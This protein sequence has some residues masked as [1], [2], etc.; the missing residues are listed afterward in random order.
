MRAVGRAPDEIVW[1]LRCRVVVPRYCGSSAI[2]MSE[3]VPHPRESTAATR[4]SSRY[5]SNTMFRHSIA[6]ATLLLLAGSAYAQDTCG[7]V[8]SS[9]TVT[10]SDALA[11]LRKSV[12][13]PVD[14]Q[15]ASGAT[16]LET[17]QSF[18][19]DEA[20]ETISCTGTGQDAE[21]KKGVA[22]NFTDN[23]DGTITDENTGL[24]WEKLSDDD[25]IHDYDDALYT[26]ED[27]FTQKIATL[28]STNFAGHNDWRLPNLNELETIRNL[29]QASPAVHSEFD[30]ACAPGCTVLTCSCT[31]SDAHWT[32]T[33]YVLDETSAWT[34]YFDDGDTY[35]TA[36]TV[37][38]YVR[39]VRGGS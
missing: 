31:A 11:V 12:G 30:T 10:S 24:E 3:F 34:V 19:Y 20:G 2:T 32:S 8:N 4:R 35:A 7:D 28:N 9:G 15:C 36:K 29:G 33:T 13:Q 26:W 1:E 38:N 17:G 25:S 21:L 5:R 6:A 16:P 18:C 39:A 37:E 14:L 23:G 22:A 27:A